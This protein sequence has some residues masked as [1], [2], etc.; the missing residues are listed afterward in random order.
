VRP[1]DAQEPSRDEQVSLVRDDKD[2]TWVIERKC[3]DCRYDP[4]AV[5]REQVGDSVR[6]LTS[7]WVAALTMGRPVAARTRPDRWSVLEYGCHVR[8]VFRR[9]DHRLARMLTEDNP[10]F[11]NWDQDATAIEERYA[12]QDPSVVAIALARAGAAV[13]RRW[14]RVGA[15]EWERTGVRSDGARFTVDRLARYLL[16]DPTHHLW[17]IATLD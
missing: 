17:D 16:H 3:P 11:D 8:D 14:D 6:T 4:S 12:W 9:F 5:D 15:G 2:W 7:S 13:A 10:T 1:T